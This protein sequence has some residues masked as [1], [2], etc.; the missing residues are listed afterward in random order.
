METLDAAQSPQASRPG[1]RAVMWGGLLAVLALT[2][3][4]VR[5]SAA[6]VEGLPPGWPAW[7][8]PYPGIE[9]VQVVGDGIVFGTPASPEQVLSFY[10]DAASR[11]GM[12]TIRDVQTSGGH[13]Y[14]AGSPDGARRMLVGIAR[15]S[16][17]P[18]GAS[19]ILTPKK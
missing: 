1:R 19:V 4:V 16:T 13:T 6:D 5:A 2:L 14:T 9:R 10:R 17:F 11:N 15:S 7:L 3:P 8:P 18:G 12:K